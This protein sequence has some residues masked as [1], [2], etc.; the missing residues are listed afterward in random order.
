MLYSNKPPEIQT[1]PKEIKT[2]NEA[3][4]WRQQTIPNHLVEIHTRDDLIVLDINHCVGDGAFFVHLVSNLGKDEKGF[5]KP[6]LFP[7]ADFFKKELDS[8]KPYPHPIWSDVIQTKFHPEQNIK[9]LRSILI[10]YRFPLNELSY[11]DPITKSLKNNTE[12]VWSAI[13]MQHYFIIIQ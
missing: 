8:V 6:F 7:P 1:L 10:D 9:D 3:I 11:F 12:N 2:M 4:S 5:Q 13:L